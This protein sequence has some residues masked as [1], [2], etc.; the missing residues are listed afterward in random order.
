[1]EILGFQKLSLVDYPEKLCSVVF[2]GGCNFR[3]P[4]CHNKSIVNQCG[5]TMDEEKL[6]K[7]LLK[8]NKYI[9]NLCISGGEPT[10]QKDLVSFI[11]NYKNLGF[12]VKLDTNGSNPAM[13]KELLENKYV[14]YVAMDLKTSLDDYERVTGKS[15]FEKKIMRSLKLLKTY[16]IDYEF[17]TTFVKGM[18]TVKSIEGLKQMVH[19]SNRFV[20]QRGRLNNEVL[21]PNKEMTS[22]T[23][24]EME[25]LKEEFRSFVKEVRLNS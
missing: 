23:K 16:P 1:M 25:A 19:N 9:S 17:R 3:C 11:K 20:L 4:Y 13:L 24:E 8:R 6:E 14:D 22:Y 2:T 21:L 15:G 12:S 7:T 18:M 10:L 5:D